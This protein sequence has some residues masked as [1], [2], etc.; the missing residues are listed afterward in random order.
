MRKQYGA[1]LESGESKVVNFLATTKGIDGTA[2]WTFEMTET[3]FQAISEK[4]NLSGLS[5]SELIIRATDQYAPS[6]KQ[7]VYTG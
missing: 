1:T 4:A 5:L 2:F 6:Q 7:A 3:E